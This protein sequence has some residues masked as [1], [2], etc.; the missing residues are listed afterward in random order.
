MTDLD[1][2]ERMARLDQLTADAALKRQGF[3]L[4]YRRYMLAAVGAAAALLG[5]GGAVTG[6]IVAIVL[7]WH[8]PTKALFSIENPAIPLPPAERCPV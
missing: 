1:I 2:R 3:E 6:A 7:R 4:G 5:A 8:W